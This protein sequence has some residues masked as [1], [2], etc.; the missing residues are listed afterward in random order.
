M[1]LRNTLCTLLLG[2]FSFS[3]MAADPKACSN[4]NSF[5]FGNPS[6]EEQMHLELINRARANPKAEAK[7]Y[8]L[9]SVTEGIDSDD[10]SKISTSAMQ[11]LT[12]N[13]KLYKAAI[14]HSKDMADNEYFAHNSQGTNKTPFVRIEEDQGY[15]YLRAGE[16]LAY[17][18]TT[19]SIDKGE[20]S[21]KLHGDLFI[22]DGYPGRGHRVN[23]LS[24]KFK[25]IGVGL[26]FGIRKSRF[27]TYYVTDDYAAHF[28]SR[29]HFIT[30]AVYDDNDNDNFYTIGEGVKGVEIALENTSS[31]GK[32]ANAGGYGIPAE[33]GIYKV[34][35]THST[36]GSYSETITVSGQ[37]IKLDVLASKFASGNADT[38]TD[39]DT[40]TQYAVS[41]YDINTTDLFIQAMA[42][43]GFSDMYDVGSVYA[44]ISSLNANDVNTIKAKV[45]LITQITGSA[46]NMTVFK[47]T[48]FAPT[49]SDIRGA[50]YTVPS[51]VEVNELHLTQNDTVVNKLEVLFIYVE[52][53]GQG[54]LVIYGTKEK[55]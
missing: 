41:T 46:D 50:T 25:E 24:P 39:T 20:S 2:S 13:V 22:D 53:D 15:N 37:N 30:G 47:L 43:D 27:N 48:S 49:Q 3:A 55:S 42:A 6:A 9:S 51:F 1:L 12:F 44:P 8:G 28:D 29:C 17:T 33:D 19:A 14:A 35:F 23:I 26:A 18:A 36:L 31:T 32:T 7:I 11:P 10:L 54:Y 16:N 21:I 4:Y 52:A 5:Y 40:T 38:N 34:T 45:E